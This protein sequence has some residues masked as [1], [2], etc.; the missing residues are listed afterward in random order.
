M[1]RVLIA[2][3]LVLALL[4]MGIASGS[5]VQ[6]KTQKYWVYDSAQ[7]KV[8]GNKLVVKAP[9][10]VGEKK[11]KKKKVFILTNKTKY[12]DPNYGGSDPMI[13]K[14]LSKAEFKDLLKVHL[15]LEIRVKKGKVTRCEISS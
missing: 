12:W 2:M 13:G 6:A 9:L 15:G 14:W 3:L 8:K 4:S 7:A 1:K 11:I 5:Y 10:Y